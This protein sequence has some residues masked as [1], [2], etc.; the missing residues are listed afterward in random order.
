MIIKGQRFTLVN[1]RQIIDLEI[2]KPEIIPQGAL[3]IMII[4]LDS[5]Q[6]VINH[7]NPQSHISGIILTQKN[8]NLTRIIIDT[9]AIASHIHTLTVVIHAEKI[10][11]IRFNMKK[12][13]NIFIRINN[14]LFDLKDYSDGRAII[15]CSI[16]RRVG[17][18]R[19]HAIG[20]SYKRGIESIYQLYCIPLEPTPH[21]KK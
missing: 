18:W 13:G 9:I 12:A 14:E 19:F 1:R 2:E 7:W 8:A 3:Q 5:N 6:H 15:A 21:Y 20:E 17:N 4:P 16:Y 11:S 10:N